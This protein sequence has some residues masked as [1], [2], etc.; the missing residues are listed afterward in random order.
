MKRVY[1][2]LIK[3]HFKENR[4]MLFLMG[5]RQVGKTTTSLD[6]SKINQNSSYLNWDNQAHRLLILEGQAAVA[7]HLN[8]DTLQEKP[9]LVIFDE[10][11][12]FP[13][14]R[15]FLKGFFDVYGKQVKILVTGSARLD[16]L[17][18]T[19]DSLM[20]RYFLYRL[21][22]FSVREILNT[23]LSDKEIQ[24]P[25]AISTKNLQDL[26]TYGGFPEPFLQ[27]NARF[28]NR[29]KKLRLNQLFQ[30]DLQDISQVREI[31]QL[32]LLAELLQAQAGQLVN[33]SDLAK[34]IQ[35]SSETVKRWIETLAN[36][37]Y[38]FTL[39]PWSKNNARSLLKEPKIFLWDWGLL[40][41]LGKKLENFVASHLLKAVHFWTDRG[42]G[43]YGLYFLRDKEKREVDFLVVKDKEPW[44]LV[45]V[46]SSLAKGISKNLYHFQKITG[47]PYALQ[48][49][50]NMPYVNKDCFSQNKPI[51]VPLSTFLSQLV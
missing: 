24:P 14:W 32:K 38:C 3:E 13:R 17:K 44:F 35:V 46:K 49:V 5:P 7:K 34:K 48:V 18:F 21:H 9:S 33:F 47:A 39:S 26:F 4:Q 50:A 25:V 12:K 19:G 15:D 20:G 28:Y 22:P 30:E 10:I 42:L 1:D 40:S 11:H 37:Y 36:L 16:I 45:E 51:K 43:E 29:W 6:V 23:K 31:S 8:L 2:K 27:K 41:D